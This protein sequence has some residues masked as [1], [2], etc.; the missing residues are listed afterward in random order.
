MMELC[1]KTLEGMERSPL[2][3]K[4]VDN[5]RVYGGLGWRKE[6]VVLRRK[7]QLDNEVVSVDILKNKINASNERVGRRSMYEKLIEIV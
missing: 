7:S 5:L 3:K 1:D 6:K 4:M 2:V